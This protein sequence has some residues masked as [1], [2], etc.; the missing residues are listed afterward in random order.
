[1]PLNVDLTEYL[2]KVRK[3]QRKWDAYYRNH[4]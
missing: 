1:M 3:A 4:P 2:T